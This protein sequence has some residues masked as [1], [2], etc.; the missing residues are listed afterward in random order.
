MR[1]LTRILFFLFFFAA[2]FVAYFYFS[3]FK[4]DERDV[5]R[6]FDSRLVAYTLE[7][8]GAPAFLGALDS[9]AGICSSSGFVVARA[10]GDTVPVNALPHFPFYV[11]IQ[12]GYYTNS[13]LNCKTPSGGYVKFSA[14]SNWKIVVERM[15][16][17]PILLEVLA[18]DAFLARGTD[19][20]F[21]W[22]SSFGDVEISS[23]GEAE[24]VFR[25]RG[26]RGENNLQL[27][28]M[29]GSVT[30]FRYKSRNQL[31]QENKLEIHSSPTSSV[32]WEHSGNPI[33]A[34]KAAL[35]LPSGV[36]ER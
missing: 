1:F 36:H 28:A 34:G 16:D 35:V 21:I 14:Q 15:I 20:K 18:G 31:Y 22:R 12:G 25:I 9:R 29:S 13:E 27:S 23:K 5:F 17:G 33:S 30:A 6:I 32:E 2:V 26:A 24:I 3:K 8:N 11:P 4:L 19:I 7:S 10:G